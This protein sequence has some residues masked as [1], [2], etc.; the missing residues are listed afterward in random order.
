M[1]TTPKGWVAVDFRGA[2]IS[3][4]ANWNVEYDTAC[5][6]VHAPGTVFVGHTGWGKCVVSPPPLVPW[7]ALGPASVT[8]T[9]PRGRTVVTGIVVRGVRARQAFNPGGIGS[10]AVPSLG[11]SIALSAPDDWRILDTL[12]HSPRA[13]VLVT[14]PYAPVPSSWGWVSFRGIK[15]AAPRLWPH[16]TIGYYGPVCGRLGIDNEVTLSTDEHKAPVEFCQFEPA[17]PTV[18]AS[19][20]GVRVDAIPA[21]ALPGPVGGVATPNP[22]RCIKLHG[23]NVCPYPNPAFG[24]LDLL[25]SDAH[26]THPVLV[27]IGLGGS[28]EVSRTILGSLQAA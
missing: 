2:Q 9:L 6:F 7:V 3:V 26:M 22:T 28:G 17:I 4:P 25:V 13:L 5:N 19:T 15:F 11:V 16:R 10:I 20:N 1:S 8:A 12:T 24:V 23:L 27:E 14:G 18:Q 21:L